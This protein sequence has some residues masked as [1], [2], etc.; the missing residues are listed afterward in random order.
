MRCVAD[1][2]NVPSEEQD[3][4]PGSDGQVLNLVHPSLYPI[5]YG[6]TLS[7]NLVTGDIQ[8]LEGPESASTYRSTRFAWLPSDFSISN[9]GTARLVSPYINNIHP[10]LHADLYP[11]I[12]KLVTLAVPFFERVL[13]DLRR[14]LSKLRIVTEAQWDTG[15]K[16]MVHGAGCIWED[17]RPYPTESDA[18]DWGDEQYDEWRATQP[19][20]LPEA[21][22]SYD[23]A[24]A[25]IRKSVS[26]SETT[27][28]IIVK[29]A[30]IILTPEKPAY[31]G[32]S[33]HVEG[34][35]HIVLWICVANSI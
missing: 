13:S 1:L 12:E 28:Q 22:P 34:Q 25:R 11:V 23:N 2:E 15:Y 32:G 16:R 10:K 20:R 3:W 18:A 4:H 26:L 30:N 31:A 17:G 29:M 14:P 8:P 7:R 9:D 19:K 6:S 21:L 27:L 35:C 33:W 24:L 5:V